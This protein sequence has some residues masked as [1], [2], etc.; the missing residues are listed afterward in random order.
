MIAPVRLA[1]KK[2]AERPALLVTLLRLPVPILS[3]KSE[4]QASNS[5]CSAVIPLAAP[6]RKKRTR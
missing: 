4:A 3:L 5:D 6:I 1:P 2:V